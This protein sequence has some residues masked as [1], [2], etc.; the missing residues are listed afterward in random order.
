MDNEENIIDNAIEANIGA[1]MADD[2]ALRSVTSKVIQAEK[3][4][5]PGTQA[6]L[7][8]SAAL[9]GGELGSSEAPPFLQGA[10]PGFASGYTIDNLGIL[11]RLV[12][13][14]ML[15]G[16]GDDP[17]RGVWDYFANTFKGAISGEHDQGEMFISWEELEARPDLQEWLSNAAEGMKQNSIR[18]MDE[19]AEDKKF[20]TKEEFYEWLDE[21]KVKEAIGELTEEDRNDIAYIQKLQFQKE[22][23]MAFIPS[24]DG[25]GIL[26]TSDTLPDIAHEPDP[27][28][29]DGRLQL[30][31]YGTL[32]RNEQGELTK[33]AA[34]M[35]R[36][37]DNP[38]LPGLIEDW[39]PG[40]EKEAGDY[41][42]PKISPW[43][44]YGESGEEQLGYQAGQ[45]ASGAKIF[46]QIAKTGW[47]GGKGLYNLARRKLFGYNPVDTS[48]WK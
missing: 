45:I 36:F 47:R 41:F 37:T 24:E 40:F 23:P 28:F 32:T 9:R 19:F 15:K 3:Q 14:D 48:G 35:F 5:L 42:Y 20:R 29:V 6:W 7:D 4:G 38:G 12:D 10:L 1:R 11:N 25:N 46:P 13:W 8:Q 30:P 22:R 16:R 26:I 43:W 27:K 17:D 39:A 31:Y 34:S 33:P 21:L 18:L 44:D 2:N